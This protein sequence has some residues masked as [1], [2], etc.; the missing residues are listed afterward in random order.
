[1]PSLC[2]YCE[3]LKIKNSDKTICCHGLVAIV[4]PDEVM[5]RQVTFATP[6]VFYHMLRPTKLQTAWQ[7][8][9]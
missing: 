3:C 2:T 4:F 5:F 1:M 7:K 9:L 8:P 6:L